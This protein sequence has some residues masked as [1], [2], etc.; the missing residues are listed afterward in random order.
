MF[1]WAEGLSLLALAALVQSSA[2]SLAKL[3]VLAFVGYDN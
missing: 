2:V 1:N 3:V